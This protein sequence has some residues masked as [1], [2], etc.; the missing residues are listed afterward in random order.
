MPPEQFTNAVSCD[1]RSDIY[2]FGI[3]LYQ[4]ATSGK[5]PFL[6]PLPRD[7]SEEESKRFWIQMYML[8]SEA[9]LPKV[10]SPLFPVAQRC[11]EKES[12]E[13]Y[14][15]FKEL[16]LDLEKLL[17]RGTGEVFKPPELKELG[18][19]EWLNKGRSF[20]TLGRFDEASAC[21]AKAF[22][23]SRSRRALLD[24]GVRLNKLGRF[25]EAIAHYDKA[26]E[27]D[28]QYIAA[29]L[30]KGACLHS[31][32]RFDEEI[33]CLN[34]AL[35]VDP[36][37]ANAWVIGGVILESLGRFDEALTCFNRALK[38]DPQCTEAWNNKGK[39]LHRL[40]RFDEALTCFNRALEIDPTEALTWYLKALVEKEIHREQD[41]IHSFQQFI[42]HAH[43]Q[44]PAEVDG[45]RQ[46]LR[47][48][49]K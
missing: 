30:S 43:G 27:I 21:N 17:K 48:L 28:P 32:G 29:W 15:S 31:L 3:V 7:N 42:E 16:R 38:I 1:E 13:R 8:H 37:N 14:R 11:L 5:L 10:N 44:Y 4:M 36:P 46:Q 35:E 26:L 33:S 24:E 19:Q 41:A 23:I 2:S 20:D 49:E 9:P 25:D 22:E 12:H 39:S 6:A 34:K 45:A 40:G 18:V 47:E